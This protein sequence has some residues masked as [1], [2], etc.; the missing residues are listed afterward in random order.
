MKVL[1]IS[2]LHYSNS[3]ELLD[4]ISDHLDGEIDL[5]LF[6][7]DLVDKFSKPLTS[8]F[9]VL[10]EFNL[11]IAA[12][13]FYITCGNHDLNRDCI[14][15]SFKS[16]I[17]ELKSEDEINTYVQDN[18]ANDFK[19]NLLHLE[20]YQNL[21][22]QEYHESDLSEL[23]AIHR[24][25][26]NGQSVVV[27]DL[28]FS[29]CAF[30]EKNKND[31]IFPSYIIRQ[32]SKTIS[33]DNVKI[34]LTHF[35]LAFLNNSC[36]R[37]VSDLI[38]KSF[39]CHFSGHSHEHELSI[40]QYSENGL[41]TCIAPTTM[42]KN[43][44]DNIGYCLFDI[45]I[46]KFNVDIINNVYYNGKF[47]QEPI[48]NFTIPTNEKKKNEIKLFEGINIKLANVID[49]A[50]HLFVPTFDKNAIKF[51]DIYTK[52]N[53]KTKGFNKQYSVE[54]SDK[55][56]HN[57]RS[58][59]IDEF[60]G[61]HNYLVYG[62][63]KCGKSVLL[64]KIFINLLTNF[65]HMRT[66]PLFVDMKE[67]YVN[68]NHNF[69]LSNLIQQ[70]YSF[71]LSFIN[72]LL[73]GH[74]IK[75]LVDNYNNSNGT[76]NTKLFELIKS[77]QNCSFIINT[78][79]FYDT[80]LIDLEGL[81]FKTVYIHDIS[82][83]NMRELTNKWPIE[84]KFDKNDV[85]KK[86]ISIFSQLNIHFNYWT[87]SMFLC[88]IEKT[89]NLKLH[90]NSELI[91]LYVENLLD[92]QKLSLTSTKTFS[93]DNLRAFLATLAHYLYIKKSD[94]SYCAKYADLVDCYEKYKSN[95]PR[96]VTDDLIP[97]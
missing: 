55:I 38:F 2:D 35:P 5:C 84:T 81:I 33:K 50:N 60:Y 44:S 88:I 72:E 8:A 63:E 43:T 14:K 15:G 85:F 12:K 7:G 21:L 18:K 53:I 78:T 26:H 69:D 24:F 94:N 57:S 3:H 25:N 95:N 23:Y 46:G 82:R 40:Y 89:D 70:H 29:W 49:K 97:V 79:Y 77:A 51:N 9:N 22:K 42:D 6:T 91:D 41:F 47:L 71:S 65:T 61:V 58:V 13:H 52:P 92:K 34:L 87:V 1:H 54:S 16:F 4:K 59:L 62:K 11:K 67:Y 39:D 36:R 73:T 90:N 93:Y 76:I 20:D 75:L 30:N 96:V 64:Y 27:V 19:S 56:G 83:T 66:I 32:I 48:V 68:D 45:D 86:M 80:P 10:K 31:I 37:S 17:K 28:N 74:N